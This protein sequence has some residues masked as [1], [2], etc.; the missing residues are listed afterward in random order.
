[1]KSAWRD[2]LSERKKYTS[3]IKIIFSTEKSEVNEITPDNHA[4][5][6]H[7]TSGGVLS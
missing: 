6:S 2:E 5:W 7:V 3:E 4:R 1:V